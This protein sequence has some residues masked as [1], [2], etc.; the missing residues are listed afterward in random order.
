MV[1]DVESRGRGGSVFVIDEGNGVNLAV[2][3]QR[4]TRLHNDVT[5]EEVRVAENELE[6]KVSVK[7][8]DSSCFSGSAKV[9]RCPPAQVCHPSLP[10]SVRALPG[11][12]LSVSPQSHS[13]PV[14]RKP[15]SA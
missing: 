5:A 3:S 14:A 8:S 15:I 10:P 12:P 6:Q 11:E 7:S 1:R 4:R 13:S 2:P 9:P